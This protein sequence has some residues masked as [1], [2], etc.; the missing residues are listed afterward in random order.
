MVPSPE[1]ASQRPPL[2]LNENRPGQVAADLGLGRLGEQLAH[3]VED[4]GVG[5]RVGPRG[6]PDR[7]LV[8]VHDLV[9]VLEALDGLVAARH[10]AGAVQLLRERGVEDVV[11][12]RRLAGPADTGHRHEAAQ[13]ERH[14][15]GLQVV[16]AGADDGQLPALGAR[17]AYQRG[18]D[19]LAARQVGAG[20]RVG[21]V[22]QV[23]DRAGHDDLAAVLTGARADVD[24]PVGGADGVL[25]VLDDD[26]R[27]AEVA[28]PGQGLD[29]PAVVA[30][31]QAD[32]RLVQDVE[33]ADQAGADLGGQPDALRLAAGQGARRAL[34]REVVEPD[35]EQEAEPGVDLLD[36]PLGDLPLAVAELDVAQELVALADR[37]PAHVGDRPATDEHRQRL[38]LEPGAVAHRAGHLAHV[39]LVAVPAPVGVGLVV[40]ALHERDRALEA[41]VVAA[42]PAVAV[43]VLDVHLVVEAVQHRGLGPG[44]QLAPRRVH[45][46]L[47]VLGERLEQPL[48]VLAGRRPGRPRRDRA[49]AQRLLVVGHDQL[50]VD[51]EAGA[52]AGALGAG[53]ERRVERERARLELVHRQRVLVGAGQPLGEPALAVLGL[54]RQVDEVEDD[55]AAG[56]PQRGLDRV[57]QP[58]LGRGLDAEPVDHDVDRVLVL[59]VELGRLGE[60]DRRPSTR[61]LL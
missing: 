6:A 2:T 52:E 4:A 46:D 53:A 9:D 38:G 30:L 54:L 40:P 19:R 1:H 12:Q 49:L 51:L 20:Q 45:A 50:G 37:E 57:G 58:A 61:A 32:R 24:D 10:G 33:D 5:R 35:V 48:E 56:Q 60:R 11:D 55:Q 8:D 26:E 34:E 43:P 28:Q 25:V 22:E 41:G 44:R 47:E 23:L 18:G 27:V 42:H 21:A 3:V 39:A 15:D 13:R 16:L 7:A 59:L 36:H 14:V 29:Q 17:P 31:V